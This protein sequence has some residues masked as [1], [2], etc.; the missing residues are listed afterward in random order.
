MLEAVEKTDEL[1]MTTHAAR[2]LEVSPGAVILWER[3]GKLKAIKTT[4][5]RRLFPRSEIER[6][7]REREK[8]GA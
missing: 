4:N 2:E 1:L 8:K 3:A 6:V 5:G 7:K